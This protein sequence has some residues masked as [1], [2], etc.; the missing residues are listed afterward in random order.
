MGI[1]K[2]IRTKL[3]LTQLQLAN[4]LGLHRTQLALAETGSR[5]LPK[6]ASLQFSILT[7]TVYSEVIGTGR[8]GEKTDNKTRSIIN[9]CC[10]KT[11][12]TCR[13]KISDYK[14]QLE[15]AKRKLEKMKATYET[16]FPALQNITAMQEITLDSKE[17]T[18]RRL[19]MDVAEIDVLK[20]LERC[21]PIAQ[22]KL[23][24]RIEELEARIK[25]RKG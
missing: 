11:A 10:Q 22:A 18:G 21:N 2:V 15:V 23:E 24:A 13:K 3:G 14:F 16:T 4:E 8:G 1:I 12:K 17:E 19:L 9:S 25:C 20:K 7:A 5:D 6:K